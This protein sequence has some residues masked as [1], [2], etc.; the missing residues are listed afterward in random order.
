MLEGLRIV[1]KDP[2][3]YDSRDEAME[4]GREYRKWK[5]RSAARLLGRV[6]TQ[7]TRGKGGSNP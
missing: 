5:R 4:V 2:I 3:G 1:A 7:G 6:K